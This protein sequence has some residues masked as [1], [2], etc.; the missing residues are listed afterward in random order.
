[1]IGAISG[2]NSYYSMYLTRGALSNQ[3]TLDRKSVV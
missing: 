3:K 2:L 1:M